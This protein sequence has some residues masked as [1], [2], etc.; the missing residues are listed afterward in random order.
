[1]LL[2]DGDEADAAEVDALEADALDVELPSRPPMQMQLFKSSCS[3]PGIQIQAF[4]SS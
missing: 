3:D 4:R 1:M 2:A